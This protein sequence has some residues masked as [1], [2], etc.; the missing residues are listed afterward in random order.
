M[1]SAIFG[2]TRTA[3]LK[4]ILASVEVTLSQEVLDALNAVHHQ[5]PMVY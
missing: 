1:A 2:A 3:Q 5:H 4:H